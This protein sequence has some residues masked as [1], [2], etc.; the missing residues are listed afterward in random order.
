MMYSVSQK[1]SPPK[2]KKLFAIFLLMVTCVTE[3][4]RGYCPHVFLCL[5][6]FWSIYLNIRM[7]CIIFTSKTP[8]ILT[9]QFCLLQ[10]S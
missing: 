5:H 8:Q 4:Y 6:Q 9:I 10:N 1:R 3:N 2:K 7:H